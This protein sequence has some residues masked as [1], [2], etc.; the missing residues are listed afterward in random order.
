MQ[1]P[2]LPSVSLTAQSDDTKWYPEG[3]RFPEAG[4]ACLVPR[5]FSPMGPSYLNS[6]SRKKRGQ[7]LQSKAQ[8]AIKDGKTE[9]SSF[10]NRAQKAD[11]DF[12]YFWRSGR[13]CT[14]DCGEPPCKDRP[15]A[16]FCGCFHLRTAQN[17]GRPGSKHLS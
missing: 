1:E 7:K 14:S 15:G 9:A 5:W 11:E 6:K 12:T 2:E 10:F 8:K 3:L 17:N 16:A 13:A 4:M